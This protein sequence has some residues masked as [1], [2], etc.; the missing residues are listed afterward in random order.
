VILEE[1][2]CRKQ[3]AGDKMLD[4]NQNP[5]GKEKVFTSFRFLLEVENVSSYST[6]SKT[7]N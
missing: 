1:T 3:V 2:G 5:G 4:R 6:L 7:I